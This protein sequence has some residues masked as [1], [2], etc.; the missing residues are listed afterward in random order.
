MALGTAADVGSV[1]SLVPVKQLALA[2]AS[3]AGGPQAMT[4]AGPLA[5]YDAPETWT[6]TTRPAV[7]SVEARAPAYA[8]T[9]RPVTYTAHTREP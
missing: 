5:E 7:R 6:A 1:Q 2:A 8:A 9:T 4:F 3:S